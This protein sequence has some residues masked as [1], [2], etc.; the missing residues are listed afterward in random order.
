[1]FKGGKDK[2]QKIKFEMEDFY[3]MSATA[4]D[5]ATHSGYLL[6]APQGVGKAQNRFCVLDGNLLHYYESED[7]DTAKGFF[8][9][10]RASI[11]ATPN[12]DK[13][14]DFPFCIRTCS[15]REI[16]LSAT[17]AELRDTWVSNL[18][19]ASISNKVKQIS[20]LTKKVADLE[21]TVERQRSHIK[22][23]LKQTQKDLL[24]GLE[25]AEEKV[26][27]ELQSSLDSIKTTA[28][29]VS[30]DFN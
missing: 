22:A 16:Y 5:R 15:T 20:D 3:D 8:L 1:M 30:S 23:E 12:K 14:S 11:M 28:Q 6:K 29:R 13:P 2:A 10:E 21:R 25:A 4:I 17:T 26:T 24:A 19:R 7:P 27:K 9:I 18:Q